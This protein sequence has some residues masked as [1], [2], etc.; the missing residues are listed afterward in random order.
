MTTTR[1]SSTRARSGQAKQEENI[2]PDSLI[3]SS[4]VD[5]TQRRFEQIQQDEDC[6]FDKSAMELLAYNSQE[7]IERRLKGAGVAGS[8]AKNLS[9]TIVEGYDSSEALI[10]AVQDDMDGRLFERILGGNDLIDIRFLLNGAQRSAAVGRINLRGGFATGFMV[11]PGVIMTNWHVFRHISHARSARIEFGFRELN[12]DGQRS[13]P[14]VFGFDVDRLFFSNRRNDM[15]IVALGRR[16][17]GPLS[18]DSIPFCRLTD[19]TDIDRGQRINVIQHPA[20]QPKQVALRDNT[21]VS[22]VDET[23]LQY[24]ADTMRGS[25]GSPAFD[26][27]WNLIGLHHSGVPRRNSRGQILDIFGRIATRRTPDDQIAWIANEAILSSALFRLLGNETFRGEARDLVDSVLNPPQV[28]ESVPRVRTNGRGD[29]GDLLDTDPPYQQDGVSSNAAHVQSAV[30]MQSDGS[31]SVTLPLEIS[32]KLGSA[33]T[34]TDQSSTEYDELISLVE[35]IGI[36]PDYSNRN[37][38]QE[39]FL[40]EELPMPELTEEQMAIAA[41]NR[42]S[43]EEEESHILHYHNFSVVMNGD[44]RIPF[45][46][47]VNIHGGKMIRIS[48]R[49]DGGKHRWITDP[50]IGDHEQT[51][52]DHYRGRRNRLD[53]G[54]LVRRLDPAWG[55]TREDAARG[56][57]DTFHYVNSAPQY[58]NFNR[59]DDR[60]GQANGLWL[61]LENFVLDNAQA[62]DQKVTVFTGPVFRDDD[63]EFLDNNV[64]IPTQYWK[65]IAWSDE[66]GLQAAA[67]LLS[68]KDMLDDDHRIEMLGDEAA[69]D[70]RERDLYQTTVAEIAELTDLEFGPLVDGEI[71]SMQEGSVAMHAIDSLNDIVLA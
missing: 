55:D 14:T 16:R 22:V 39:S 51:N 9:R 46:T 1:K 42:E 64:P 66:D 29:A 67:F 3:P 48:R 56:I 12:I 53:R 34:I 5:E 60:R 44:R 41:F 10:D 40:D 31:V 32:V 19:E 28:D 26:D 17:S 38:Y 8:R 57:V 70:F 68:Q 2:L 45:Y 6:P 69:F 47:A 63:P 61:G 36:D 7:S 15:A 30:A 25:S 43:E 4:V 37:G 59:R 24:R 65:V 33:N 27:E 23:F 49:R 20:G 50:R 35:R 71:E 52:N 11:A 13:T 54:H 58:D 62:N 18:A 21:A